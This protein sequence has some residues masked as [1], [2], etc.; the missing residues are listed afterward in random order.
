M[1]Q[2]KKEEDAKDL[3]LEHNLLVESA[4]R[5]EKL[6][7]RLTAFELELNKVRQELERVYNENEKL[8]FNKVLYTEF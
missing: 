2:I 1:K 4:D 8:V 3:N 6:Q 5:E 7:R